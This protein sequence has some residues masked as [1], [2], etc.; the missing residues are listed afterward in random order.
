LRAIPDGCGQVTSHEHGHLLH[1]VQVDTAV[2][3]L[4]G[5]PER[6]KC[7]PEV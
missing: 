4:N 7:E 5:N 6:R 3:E 2:P 1:E